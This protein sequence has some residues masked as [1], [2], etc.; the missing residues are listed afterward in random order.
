[1]HRA[2]HL[3]RLLNDTVDVLEMVLDVLAVADW[4]LVK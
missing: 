1:M 2:L 3:A 4:M